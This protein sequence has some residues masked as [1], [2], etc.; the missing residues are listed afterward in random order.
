VTLPPCLIFKGQNLDSGWIPN[1]TP[2]DWKFVTSKKGWTSDLIRFEW[3]KTH[4]QPFV[5]KSTN[6][7]Y[8]LITDGHSSH[9]TARFIAYCI[10]SKIDLFLLPLYLS[11]KTQPFDLSIFGP[12]KTVINLEVDRIFRQSTM[13]LLRIEWT[14]AYIKARARCFKPSSTKSGFQKAGIYP[15]NPKIL[16][17]T[18]TPPP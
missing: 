5:S 13:R 17:S 15:F 6:S 2:V 9:I 4:F 8:L 14:S 18:L 7:R 3:L 16:L 10:T 12:L 11:H 1:E